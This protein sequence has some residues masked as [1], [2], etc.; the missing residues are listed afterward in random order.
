LREVVKVVGDKIS[1]LSQ[2]RFRKENPC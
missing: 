2:V 1:S